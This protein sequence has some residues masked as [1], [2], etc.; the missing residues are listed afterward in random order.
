MTDMAERKNEFECPYCGRKFS[1]RQRLDDHVEDE[2][3]DEAD[4]EDWEEKDTDED[5]D[6]EEEP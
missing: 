5:W 6:E 4:E 3:W 1:S 2:H